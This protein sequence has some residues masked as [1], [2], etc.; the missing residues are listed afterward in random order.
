MGKTLRRRNNPAN[1]GASTHIMG[2]D[3]CAPCT[4]LFCMPLFEIGEKRI[5]DRAGAKH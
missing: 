5:P 2:S 1:A 4:F 3:L